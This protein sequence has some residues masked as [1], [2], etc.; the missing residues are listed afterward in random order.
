MRLQDKLSAAATATRIEY[1]WWFILRFRA[2]G[3]KLLDR[4]E[5]LNSHRLLQLSRSI[6]RHSTIAKKLESLYESRWVP[7]GLSHKPEQANV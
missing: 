4:G 3:R 2:R 5:P 6:D 1:H 7:A